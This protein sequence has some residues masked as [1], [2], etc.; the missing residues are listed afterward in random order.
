LELDLKWIRDNFVPCPLQL[1]ELLLLIQ[2]FHLFKPSKES[3]TD[4]SRPLVW[5][6]PH[7]LVVVVVPVSALAVLD[8]CAPPHVR[9]VTD[10]LLRV[11]LP[12]LVETDVFMAQSLATTAMLAQTT[13]ATQHEDASFPTLH[14][15]PPT[16]AE[17]PD[18]TLKWDALTLLLIVTTTIPAHETFAILTLDAR[19][20]HNPATSA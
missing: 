4:L 3:S 14:V 18:V 11:A 12:M 9:M 1:Q 8:V 10:A 6:F 19:I 20:Q 7:L 5:L 16:D 2:P 17:L 13:C 15:Q